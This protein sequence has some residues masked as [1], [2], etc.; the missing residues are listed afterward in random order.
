MPAFCQTLT[1]SGPFAAT[2]L[3]TCMPQIVTPC[4][5]VTLASRKLTPPGAVVV[6]TRPLWN[7]DSRREATAMRRE[8]TTGGWQASVVVSVTVTSLQALL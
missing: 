5:L 7:V 4:G 6:M 8:S 3:L 1:V 2:L